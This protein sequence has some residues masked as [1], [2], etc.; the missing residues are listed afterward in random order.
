MKEVAQEL[1]I[2]TSAVKN[3]RDR[4]FRHMLRD[5]ELR[6]QVP[7]YCHNVGLTRFN[8]TNTSI[9]ELIVL[10]KEKYAIDSGLQMGV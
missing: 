7:D 10:K 1:G 6:M 8:S 3:V 4:A 5:N 9:V 2:S